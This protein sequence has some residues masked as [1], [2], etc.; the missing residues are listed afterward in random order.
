MGISSASVA[1]DWIGPAG[2]G[3]KVQVVVH[4]GV[5]EVGVDADLTQLGNARLQVHVITTIDWSSGV[6]PPPPSPHA[7]APRQQRQHQRQ[8]P[9]P[10]HQNALCAPSVVAGTPLVSPPRAAARDDDRGGRRPRRPPRR[11]PPRT[12]SGGRGGFGAA[13][14]RP[15][16]PPCP[17]IAPSARRRLVRGPQIDRQQLDVDGDDLAGD[18][19]RRLRSRARTRRAGPR[20]G[21]GRASSTTSPRAACCRPACRRR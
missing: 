1:P 9:A 3:G 2:R 20:P 5:G 17:T 18:R 12:R 19:R 8:S 15:A 6:A 13:P 11:P 14:D 4:G 21:G 10:H 16:A 7:P